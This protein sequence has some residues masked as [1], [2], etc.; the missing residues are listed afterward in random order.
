MTRIYLI[1]GLLLAAV[2]TSCDE[3][4]PP[5][6]PVQPVPFTQVRFD[7]EFW[8]PRLETNRTVTIPHVF[9]MSEETGRVDNFA[10]AG[11]LI[12][13]QQCGSYPFDDT[14]VYK[15]IEG[16]SY[17]L[18]LQR[19]TA[20]EAYL[21][22]LIAL[23]AAAQEPDGYLYS[24]RTNDAEELRRWFG[25]RRWERL[26]RSHELYNGGH[27]YEAAAAHYVA[28]GKRNLLEVALKNADLIDAT[29]GP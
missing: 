26:E 8:S 23:I 6:Y 19:D 16:A 25:D 12:E 14:D 4:Q 27:L 7:D 3:G 2:A 11:G 15:T 21:D 18:M 17:S 28:T 13:G 10:I 5:D 24:A 29:F 1:S 9:A 22:S 20:L